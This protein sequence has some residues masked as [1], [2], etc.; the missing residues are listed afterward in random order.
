MSTTS[1][2]PRA[3]QSRITEQHKTLLDAAKGNEKLILC[4]V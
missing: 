3:A 2:T 4:S 1:S